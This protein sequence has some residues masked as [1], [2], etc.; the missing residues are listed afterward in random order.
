MVNLAGNA[1]TV[2]Q[3][4]SAS[5][6][7]AITTVTFAETTNVLLW[8]VCSGVVLVSGGC[9]IRLFD[10]YVQVKETFSNSAGGVIPTITLPIIHYMTMTAGTHTIIC[11]VSDV[12]GNPAPAVETTIVIMGAKR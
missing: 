1:V 6:S 8:G 11:N 9:T 7:Q 5:G 12:Y 2:P 3:V 4:S 10:N